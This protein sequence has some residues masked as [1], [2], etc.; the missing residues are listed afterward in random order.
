MRR[1]DHETLT[2]IFASAM[3]MD[4]DLSEPTSPALVVWA[5]HY[6]NESGGRPPLL[7]RF[8]HSVRFTIRYDHDLAR[9]SSAIIGWLLWQPEVESDSD[10][11]QVLRLRGSPTDPRL[12]VRCGS[13]SFR[14]LE[15]A[16]IAEMEE[17]RT[18]SLLRPGFAPAAG[19]PG[20]P[21]GT[22]DL[23]SFDGVRL[24]DI[25]LSDHFRSVGVLLESEDGPLLLRFPVVRRFELTCPDPVSGVAGPWVLG[26]IEQEGATYRLPSA[27][28][29]PSLSIDSGRVSVTPVAAKL[30]RQLE[31]HRG[32][33]LLRLGY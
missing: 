10:G 16:R 13:V 21:V 33:H 4:V 14:E 30:V 24:L 8:D 32:P 22:A 28:G 26:P 20:A 15:K 25:D 27:N 31:Q 6:G 5:D 29:Q 18:S 3:V 23:A 17:N 19:S 2:T 7:V 1:L 11:D 9:Y 12:E